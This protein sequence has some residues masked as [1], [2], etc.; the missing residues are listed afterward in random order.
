MV[1]RLRSPKTA[2]ALDEAIE[3]ACEL[4]NM[5]VAERL[6][7]IYRLLLEDYLAHRRVSAGGRA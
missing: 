2:A 1:D 7:N 3:C 5:V 4:R 6:F